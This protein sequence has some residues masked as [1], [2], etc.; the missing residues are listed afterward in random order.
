[1]YSSPWLDP[2]KANSQSSLVL[3]EVRIEPPLTSMNFTNTQQKRHWSWCS[4][5]ARSQGQQRPRHFYFGI[6]Q[7]SGAGDCRRTQIK[8]QDPQPV[9]PDGPHPSNQRSNRH[10]R[11]REEPFPQLQPPGQIPSRHS[12][13]QCRRLV[14]PAPERPQKGRHYRSR[15][16]A[17]L[18]RQCAGTAHFNADPG[19]IFTHGSLRPHRQCLERLILHWL[20]RPVRLC[21]QQR[22]P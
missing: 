13:Q 22:R 5:T 7:R 12:H 19:A 3:H 20:P 8:A 1:M 2:I 10:C 17:S 4:Q 15:V 18:R 9:Y 11:G 14:K 16:H 21:R 6:I